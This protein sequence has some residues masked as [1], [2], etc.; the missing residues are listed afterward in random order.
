MGVLA[1]TALSRS[2]FN[3]IQKRNMKCRSVNDSQNGHSLRPGP[4]AGD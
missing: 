1:S 3:R 2:N 4:V